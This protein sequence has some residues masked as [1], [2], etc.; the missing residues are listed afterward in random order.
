MNSANFGRGISLS[1]WTAALWLLIGPAAAFLWLRFPLTRFKNSLSSP[2]PTSRSAPSPRRGVHL[3]QVNP[4]K[5]EAD[6]D[7]DIIAIHGLDTVAGH[8]DLGKPQGSH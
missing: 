7:I 8:L 6:T 5:S 3:C 1:R 4:A 2:K